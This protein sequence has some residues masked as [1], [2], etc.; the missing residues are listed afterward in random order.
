MAY[1]ESP[2][3]ISCTQG[4]FTKI[5]PFHKLQSNQHF[6]L[7]SASLVMVAELGHWVGRHTPLKDYAHGTV[8]TGK[9]PKNTRVVSRSLLPLK[10]PGGH[11]GCLLGSMSC[12][13]SSLRLLRGHCRRKRTP[14]RSRNPEIITLGDRHG[15]DSLSPLVTLPACA[16]RQCVFGRDQLRALSRERHRL[17]QRLRWVLG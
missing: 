8:R 12:K 14:Q 7:V 13:P 2:L 4:Q 11:R 5:I 6:S 15:R 10:P 17:R 9:R 3:A 1:G 16:K